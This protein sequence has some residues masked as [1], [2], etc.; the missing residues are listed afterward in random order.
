MRHVFAF[1]LFAALQAGAGVAGAAGAQGAASPAPD[2]ARGRLLYETH[3]IECHDT[4]MHWREGK[5]AKD[6]RSLRTQVDR[7]QG[8]ASLKW[9]PEDIESVTRHLN[10]TIYKFPPEQLTGAVSAPLR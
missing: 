2:P 6:Y 10:D 9:T 3:C 4:G 7:W 1:A 5:A 8:N